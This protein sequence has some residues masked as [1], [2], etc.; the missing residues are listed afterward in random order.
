MKILMIIVMFLCIGAFF[1]ISQ[2]NL[3]LNKSENADL[4]LSTYKGWL[5]KTFDNL[6]TLT[7]QVV[8]M[9]WLPPS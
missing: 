4:F 6:G 5:S 3:A 7:G 1:I 2:N 8:K 9:E